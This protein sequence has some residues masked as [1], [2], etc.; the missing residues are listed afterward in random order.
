MKTLP[1]LVLRA[2]SVIR[3][4]K[5][6]KAQVSIQ[7]RIQDLPGGEGAS[8]RGGQPNFFRKLHETEEILARGRRASLVPPRSTTGIYMITSTVHH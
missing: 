5:K 7:W 8:W 4:Q 2:W 6:K 3:F 1:F